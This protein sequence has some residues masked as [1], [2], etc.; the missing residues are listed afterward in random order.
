M[1]PIRH[2]SSQN[3]RLYI[4]PKQTSRTPTSNPPGKGTRDPCIVQ[5]APGI[6]GRVLRIPHQ[7]HGDGIPARPNPIR[8]LVRP[9][10][11]LVTSMQDRLL[12]IRTN[13]Y[14]GPKILRPL[15]SLCSDWVLPSLA[16][17]TDSGILLPNASSTRSMCRF[18]NTLMSLRPICSLA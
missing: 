13:P 18:S 16:K 9:Q 12:R 2:Q 7:P 10:T 11:L 1:C 17:L 6:L 15:L 14:S 4:R 5:G 3:R 8:A